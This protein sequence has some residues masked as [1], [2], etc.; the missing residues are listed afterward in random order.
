MFHGLFSQGKR[1]CRYYESLGLC[2]YG[3]R[4]KFDHP[5]ALSSNDEG[6]PVSETPNAQ[7]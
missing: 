6:K 4:C 3:R 5:R 1:V 2:K 7:E